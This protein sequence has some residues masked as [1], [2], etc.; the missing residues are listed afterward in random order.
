[1]DNKNQLDNSY[2]FKCAFMNIRGQTG[3]THDKEMQIENFLK[4]H[5][6]DALHLQETYIDSDSFSKCEYINANY[7][8]WANNSSN[9]YGTSCI[10]RSD[11]NPENFRFD[12]QGRI[13]IYDI[14]NLTI[15]NIYFHSGT[16][17]KSKTEREHLSSEI[18]PNLLIN[19]KDNGYIGGDWNCITDKKDAT[20]H[21]EQKISRN[22]DRLR[23]NKNW[24]DSYRTL[25]PSSLEYSRFYEHTQISG[26]NRIDR[27]Y[28][29]GEL[30]PISAKYI[31]LAFSDHFAHIVVFG[32]PDMV[33]KIFSPKARP[34]FK[35]RAEVINDATFQE[36][37]K[38]HMV[39]WERVR[40]FQTNNSGN[41]IWWEKLVKPGIW[42]IAKERSK[43][44]SKEKKS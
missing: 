21:P 6:I 24:K 27:C 37:I 26:A 2:Q 11:L 30:K 13:Q 34:N 19:A 44:I 17:S 8:I 15:G 40:Q 32:I 7:N 18:L 31:P 43:E 3:L 29:F 28:H 39:N 9:K 33:S 41:L 36:R 10:I 5:N 16:D 42:R 14:G 20:H 12:T 4:I 1:M 22:L 38:E 23:L 25:N 35:L